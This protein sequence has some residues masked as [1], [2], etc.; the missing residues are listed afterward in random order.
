MTLTYLYHRHCT[1]TATLVTLIPKLLIFKTLRPQNSASSQE[2]HTKLTS[3]STYIA[4]FI[5]KTHSSCK[6]HSFVTQLKK[7]VQIL[8]LNSWQLGLIAGTL[9]T[10]RIL[11][12]VCYWST[13]AWA[14]VRETLAAWLLVVAG[15]MG[16][17][18]QC[19][20]WVVL[21]LLLSLLLFS[22]SLL[23]LLVLL[24]L[25][26]WLELSFSSTKNKNLTIYLLYQVCM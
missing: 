16:E 20:A 5:P 23:L 26:K 13:D 10:A 8:T 4:N 6:L 7:I 24:L 9:A 18:G 21:L 22:S 14:A 25:L 19:C 11:L 12:G 1:L 2:F 3:S 17:R 15:L